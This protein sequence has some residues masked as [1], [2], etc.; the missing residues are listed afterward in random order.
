M[1]GS[2]GRDNWPVMHGG[3]GWQVPDAFNIAQ[4][5]CGRWARQPDAAQRVAIVASLDDAGRVWASLVTGPARND[6]GMAL[7]VGE[8]LRGRD[9]LRNAERALR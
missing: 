9:S 4:A 3:F 5:C 7:R 6:V 2:Q 1:A 8:P